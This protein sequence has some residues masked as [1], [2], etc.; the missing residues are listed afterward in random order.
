MRV[1]ILGFSDLQQSES[2]QVYRYFKN[3]GADISA[4]VWGNPQVPDDI[5]VIAVEHGATFSGLDNFDLLVRGPAIHPQ[6]MP[7]KTRTTTLTNIFL[8]HCPTKNLIGITGTKGKGTTSTLVAKMLQAAGHRVFLGGN[9]G[10]PLLDDLSSITP[11]DW[12]VLEMSNFQLI[13]VQYSPHIATC[14]MVVPEHLDWHKDVAEYYAAKSN[15][16]HHQTDTDVAIYHA[17]NTTS[18]ALAALSAGSKIPYLEPP[19]AYVQDGKI[20]IDG[21]TVCDTNDIKLLGEHNWQNVCAAITTVWQA[22][23]HNITAMRDVLSSFTGLPY[24]LELVRELHGIRYYNDSFSTTP[25]TATVAVQAFPQP[26][27]MILGGSS[28][29]A[30]FTDLARTIINS[31]VRAV[32]VIGDNN[33]PHYASDGPVIETALREHG[34]KDIVSLVKPGGATMSE[35]VIAAQSAAQPG[36]AVVLSAGCA[37]FDM[38]AN[39]KERGEQ[40]TSAVQTLA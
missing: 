35:I 29:K 1:A 11:A 6:Q 10:V 37:S 21:K 25:E 39:Y 12:V 36:D 22:G 2:L 8:E 5:H 30:N 19:G 3:L 38:F 15:I 34:F 31:N 32:V 18:A 17:K 23:M 7:T 40:F 20:S 13:D 24:H 9:I 28:K 16:F 27:I 26:K 4:F 14:L 33:H